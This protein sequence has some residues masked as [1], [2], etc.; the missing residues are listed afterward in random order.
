MA[1]HLSV[2]LHRSISLGSPCSAEE[3]KPSKYLDV[4]MQYC[5]KMDSTGISVNSEEMHDR[6]WF[7]AL[8]DFNP[9]ID[10]LSE[11][12]NASARKMIEQVK[13]A[14]VYMCV[15]L[16]N[17]VDTNGF[18]TKEVHFNWSEEEV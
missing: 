9:S 8:V 16:S 10:N 12:V 18:C 7:K 6:S 17:D 13:P 15:R 2:T 11:V 3:G 5:P 1:K 14:E 4:S